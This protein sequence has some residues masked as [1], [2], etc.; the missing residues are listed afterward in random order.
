M[1][2]SKT[3]SISCVV[4]FICL[5][6][7]WR[8]NRNLAYIKRPKTQ[9]KTFPRLLCSIRIVLYFLQDVRKLTRL[10]WRNSQPEEL[11]PLKNKDNKGTKRVC[12]PHS[13]CYQKNCRQAKIFF[14]SADFVVWTTFK[15]VWKSQKMSYSTLRAKRATFTFWK[16]LGVKQC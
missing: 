14:V 9:Y 4:S 3:F 11:V 5:L 8:P 7:G 6:A 12:D 2:L 10:F 16:T 1:F 13:P 15:S